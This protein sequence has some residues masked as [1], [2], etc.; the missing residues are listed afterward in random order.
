MVYFL[1]D[2]AFQKGTC[3]QNITSAQSWGPESGS[4]NLNS[5]DHILLGSE[6]IQIT[7]VNFFWGYTQIA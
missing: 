4:V 7:H 5:S 6:F 2:E 1:G 3:I